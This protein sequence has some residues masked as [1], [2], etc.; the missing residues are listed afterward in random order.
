MKRKED[1][2]LRIFVA[3]K[4]TQERNVRRSIVKMDDGREAIVD[5]MGIYQPIKRE[6][7]KIIVDTHVRGFPKT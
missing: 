4:L 6:G 2:L 5:A 7:D 1:V 3:G